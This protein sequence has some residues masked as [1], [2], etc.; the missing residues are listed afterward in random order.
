MRGPRLGVLALTAISEELLMQQFHN[1]ILALGE[2]SDGV[3][4]DTAISV[5]GL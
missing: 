4:S 2:L 5:A 1:D 3:A